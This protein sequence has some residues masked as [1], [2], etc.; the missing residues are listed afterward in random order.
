MVTGAFS[1]VIE[2]SG[3]SFTTPVALHLTVE[4][5][6]ISHLQLYEDTLLIAQAF[7]VTDDASA[8]GPDDIPQSLK[9]AD[10]GEAGSL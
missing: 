1:H 6:K 9:T 4:A 3:R 8:V 5:G 2:A 10:A 7:G